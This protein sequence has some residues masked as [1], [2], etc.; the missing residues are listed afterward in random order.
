MR[1]LRIG[2]KIKWDVTIGGNIIYTILDIDT[3]R[4]PNYIG[5]IEIRQD[6]LFQWEFCGLI[7]ESW[8]HSYDDLNQN[9]NRGGIIIIKSGIEP[10]KEVKKF[11]L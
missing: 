10:I 2:D 4:E 3:S 9:L 11:T 8:C 1:K 5:H 7:H 6:I